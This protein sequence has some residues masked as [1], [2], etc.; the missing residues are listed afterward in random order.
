ML[1]LVG[2]LSVLGALAALL[3]LAGSTLA[4]GSLVYARFSGRPEQ[5]PIQRAPAE[6]ALTERLP[7]GQPE[8]REQI[9]P[10]EA[11]PRVLALVA[12]DVSLS[13]EARAEAACALAEVGSPW[14]LP[15]VA[16]ALFPEAALRRAALSLLLASDAQGVPLLIDLLDGLA[17]PA[18]SEAALDL[19]EALAAAGSVRAV[20]AL[21]RLEDRLPPIPVHPR[22]SRLKKA[23]WGAVRQLQGRGGASAM[24]DDEGLYA[25][26]A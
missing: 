3:V 11:D 12:L 13:V 17:D 26:S 23:I 7:V 15:E 24:V 8:L 22:Q 10:L 21:R 19:V 18:S 1:G 25:L 6:E 16:L 4:L 2:L 14:E 9:H 20:P 5:A